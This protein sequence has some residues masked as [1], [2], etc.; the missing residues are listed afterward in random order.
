MLSE[1]HFKTL[2]NANRELTRQFQ[3]LRQARASRDTDGIKQAEMEYYHSLQHYMPRCK[4]LLLME[5]HKSKERK[6]KH[7][8]GKPDIR[9][10]HF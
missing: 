2:E 7:R 8:A 5:T 1:Q 9:R 3:K 10:K 4:M 6:P